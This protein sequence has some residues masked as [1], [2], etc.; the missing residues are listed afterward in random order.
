VPCAEL[1]VALTASRVL[2]EIPSEGDRTQVEVGHHWAGPV[3]QE[4]IMIVKPKV[5][6]LEG[7]GNVMNCLLILLPE[8]EPDH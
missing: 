6:H 7:G 8:P 4:A 3:E 2:Q 5:F 1:K